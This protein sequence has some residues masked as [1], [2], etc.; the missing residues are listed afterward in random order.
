MTS[1]TT[2]ILLAEDDE[3][4]VIFMQR[5]LSKAQVPHPM[6]VVADGQEAIEYLAGVGKFSIRFRVF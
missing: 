4:D 3:N 6:H 5:A 2:C 1:F